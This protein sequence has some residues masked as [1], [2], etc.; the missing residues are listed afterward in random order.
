M[1]YRWFV[2]AALS[3]GGC[4]HAVARVTPVPGQD[5]TTW[6]AIDCVGAQTNCEIAAGGA[7]PEGYQLAGSRGDVVMR[8]HMLV[9]CKGQPYVPPARECLD[10]NSCDTGQRCIF[11]GAAKGR[12]GL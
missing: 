3:I 4:A 2:G 6:Y 8:G 7:C 11:D 5:G 12:C 10:D 9:K 1:R